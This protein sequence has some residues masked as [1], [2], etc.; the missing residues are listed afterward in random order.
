MAYVKGGNTL[1]FIQLD[2]SVLS[3]GV[4]CRLFGLRAV[5]HHSLICGAIE[6][7]LLILTID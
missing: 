6:H 4:Y 1:L 5:N 3:Y 2:S 7:S